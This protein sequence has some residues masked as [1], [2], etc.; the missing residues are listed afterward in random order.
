VP[1]L[2]SCTS[3]ASRRTLRCW[4][5]ADRVTSVKQAAIAVAGSSSDQTSRTISR[6][7]GSANA[8]SAASTDGSVSDLLRKCQLKY[9]L[10][11][12]RSRLIR[13]RTCW[14][15]RPAR[16]RRYLRVGVFR[17]ANALAPGSV[18]TD[19][20]RANPPE[21]Q[22]S[23]ANSCLQKRIAEPEEMIGPALLFTS[24]AGSFITGQVLIADGGM[25]PH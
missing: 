7:R 2:R 24:D 10:D 11:K 16:Q 6:R 20:T 1:S 12:A 19:M 4:E 14:W 3:P 17:S 9:V 21:F 8:L 18:D 13:R 23:M 22:E 25:A 15:K 5:I